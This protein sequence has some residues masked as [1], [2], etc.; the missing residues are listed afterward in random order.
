MA[1]DASA[2]YYINGSTGNLYSQS[3]TGSPSCQYI[4]NFGNS[5]INALVADTAGILYA[6]GI[7]NQINVSSLFRFQS[8]TVTVVGNFPPNIFSLGDLFFYE[9]RL[10][11]LA[12]DSNQGGG[13]IVEVDMVNPSQSCIYMPLP[14]WNFFGAFSIKTGSISKSFIVSCDYLGL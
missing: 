13:W 3:I 9:H 1:V 6:A 11:M 8:G 5:S 10:F 2:F 12:G 7:Q 14:G 4:G